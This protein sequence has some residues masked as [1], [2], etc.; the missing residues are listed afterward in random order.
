MRSPARLL[1]VALAAGL[2]S[3]ERHN[4]TAKNDAEWWRLEGDRQASAQRL[5]LLQN[6]LNR[7]LANQQGAGDIGS[8]SVNLAETKAA[9]EKQRNRLTGEITELDDQVKDARHQWSESKRSAMLGKSLATLT[10]RSGRTYENVT[11]TGVTDAGI[12]FRHENGT[13]RFGAYELTSRQMDDFGI[14]SADALAAHRQE[15]A[16]SHA[17]FN[18]VEKARAAQDADDDDSDDKVRGKTASNRN[19]KSTASNSGSS[20]SSA[21]RGGSSS[22]GNGPAIASNSGLSGN[23]SRSRLNDSPRAVGRPASERPYRPSAYYYGTGYYYW[24]RPTTNYVR[25]GGT[26]TPVVRGTPSS[27]VV[28]QPQAPRPPVVRP[29]PTTP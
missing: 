29:T 2:P 13:A 27:P 12:E 11:I 24:N 17:Y 3:C 8:D 22:S 19:K 28:V 5:T 26:T 16:D 25:G 18:A 9:L 15:L 7:A 20:S 1:L 10:S 4:A 23:G 6:Q 14:E 21:S